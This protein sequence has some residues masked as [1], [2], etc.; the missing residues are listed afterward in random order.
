M[1]S[2]SCWDYRIP[3]SKLTSRLL[4]TYWMLLSCLYLFVVKML[5]SQRDSLSLAV[6]LMSLLAV[7]QIS[8]DVWVGPGESWIYWTMGCGAVGTC[9]GQ[10]K[11]ES[12][13]P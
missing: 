2:Q 9:A 3:G 5:R 8:K 13:G 7:S 11:S 6:I 12:T 10:R 1:R 4:M